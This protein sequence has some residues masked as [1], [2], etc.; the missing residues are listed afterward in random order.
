MILLDYGIKINN[1][2]S[3]ALY[4]YNLGIRD[5]LETKKGILPNSLFLDFLLENGL[6]VYKET[7]TRDIICIEFTFGTRSYEEEINKLEKSK[8]EWNESYTKGRISAEKYA[9][10]KN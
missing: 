4:G 10:N 1:F 7:S 6:N 9:Q 5:F 3:G 2:A 8:K